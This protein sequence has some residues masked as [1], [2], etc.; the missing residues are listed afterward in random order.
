MEDPYISII[1]PVYNAEQYLKD[2]FES[3][4]SQTLTHS[5]YEVLLIDNN[6]TD[7]T[8]QLISK[9]IKDNNACNIKYYF[10]DKKQ[11]SYAARNFGLDKAVGNIFAFTDADCILDKKWVQ[12]IYKFYNDANNGEF[13]LSGQVIIII[14]DDSNIWEQFDRI[15]YLNMDQHQIFETVVTANLAVKKDLFFYVGKFSE[16]VSTGD[17]EWAI[18]AKHKGYN[19]KYSRDLVVRHPSRKSIVEHAKKMKRIGYGR[20]RKV[21]VGKNKMILYL[22]LQFFKIFYVITNIKLSKKMLSSIGVM[23][24]LYFNLCFI[25]LRF[26]QFIGFIEGYMG[27]RNKL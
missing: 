24:V 2:L 12:N 16:I 1:I 4:H 3:I 5:K 21:K 14:E 15:L 27:H 22:P 7:Q 17:S 13:I 23:K 19:I 10:F 18:R 6:S 20:G 8:K 25:Y 9:E 26:V 11:C